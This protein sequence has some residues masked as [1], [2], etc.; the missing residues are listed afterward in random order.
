M[1]KNR[2]F[3]KGFTLVE[4]AVSM[5]LIG[6]VM[7]AIL[8]GTELIENSRIIKMV[9][10]LN[11]YQVATKNFR[12]VYGELPG[13]LRAPSV[14]LQDCTSTQCAA[15]GNG[16]GK[17]CLQPGMT[18][19][20]AG[21]LMNSTFGL[22]AEPVAYWRH[23]IAAN[24]I[25]PFE[26]YEDLSPAEKAAS[27]YSGSWHA[28]GPLTPYGGR[29]MVHYYDLPARAA[30]GA[31]PPFA[32]V[33]G[34]YMKLSGSSEQRGVKPVTAARLDRKIDDGVPNSGTVLAASTTCLDP[35]A[36][37]GVYQY[38]INQQAEFIEDFGIWESNCEMNIR[39]DN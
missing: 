33:R 32:A 10:Q 1:L 16:D 5:V 36:G 37:A 17:I 21:G 19:T 39:L 26:L 11:S 8:K 18:C 24:M 3:P 20:S 28:Y 7:V 9:S 13:D 34:H 14:K 25:I 35:D 27:P 15:S 38:A 29:Y 31:F 12:N 30:V 4:L 2:H 6:I 23:L 22:G